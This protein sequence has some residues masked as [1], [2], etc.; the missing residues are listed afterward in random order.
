[1]ASLPALGL[2]AADQG[3]PAEVLRLTPLP[4]IAGVQGG[5]LGFSIEA[6]WL[7]GR[8]DL[9]AP[10]TVHSSLGLHFIDHRRPDMPPLGTIDEQPVWRRDEA[11]GSLSFEARSSEGL[12]FG[13]TATPEADRVRLAFWVRNKTGQPLRHVS[14]QHCLVLSHSPQFSRRNTLDTTYA[15][16][17]GQWQCLSRTTPTAADK[18][19]DPWILL[20]VADGPRDLGGQRDMPDGWWVVN[21][22]ADSYLI[23]RQSADG[24]HLVAI[25]WDDRPPG[26]LMSNTR[27]PCLHGGP[28]QPVDLA[29]GAS[30]TWHGVIYLLSS[31]PPRLAELYRQDR[32]TA[33]R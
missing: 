7:A 10:E 26:L 11:T 3:T 16:I 1:M 28:M 9:R 19:R 33:L 27:I 32:A 23:A 13:T 29:P 30:Y 4:V 6:P 5:V 21:Q 8:L 14:S 22:V 2:W 25:T 18:G 15:W 20:P 12:V 24:R 31:G 17:G